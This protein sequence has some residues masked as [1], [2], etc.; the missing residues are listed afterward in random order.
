MIEIFVVS[1]Q[2]FRHGQ[3]I[4]AEG[5]PYLAFTSLLPAVHYALS[6]GRKI[7]CALATKVS[8]VNEVNSSEVVFV[9][10]FYTL[11]TIELSRERVSGIVPS[12][13][14]PEEGEK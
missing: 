13:M 1:E 3:V 5:E 8:R 4:H 9:E 14:V 7:T 2:E 10:K 12:D 11:L 6:T